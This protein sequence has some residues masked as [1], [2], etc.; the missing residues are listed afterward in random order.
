[1]LEAIGLTVL[2]GL[3]GDAVKIAALIASVPE[4]SLHLSIGHWHVTV[5]DERRQLPRSSL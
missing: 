2:S 5:T 4:G 3:A 1:M